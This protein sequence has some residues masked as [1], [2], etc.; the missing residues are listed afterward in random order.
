MQPDVVSYGY[1]W[2]SLAVWFIVPVGPCIAIAAGVT[3]VQL[4]SPCG[5]FRCTPIDMFLR[6]C[7]GI[8]LGIR[9]LLRVTWAYSVAVVWIYFWIPGMSVYWGGL[10]VFNMQRFRDDEDNDLYRQLPAMKLCEQFVEAIPQL[11]IALTFY[12][13]NY[14]WLPISDLVFGSVTMALSGGSII[15]GVVSGCCV[16]GRLSN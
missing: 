16:L 5:R 7:G 1:F 13:N 10:K 9:Y 12:L 2:C 11:A 6:D 8:L 4:P 14:H 3:T 15:M